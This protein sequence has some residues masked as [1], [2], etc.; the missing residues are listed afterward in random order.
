MSLDVSDVKAFTARALDG[1]DGIPMVALGF[2][3]AGADALRSGDPYQ[4]RT[5]D[6]RRSTQAVN[7]SDDP[8]AWEFE[9]EM[10][11]DYASFVQDAG[12]SRFDDVGEVVAAEIGLYLLS[13]L[14][15]A[16]R[17]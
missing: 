5:G 2:V 16:L 9:L 7:I 11:E 17:G 13:D 6:L 15:G 3:E 10:G 14:G 1:F 4:N 12:F 8:N